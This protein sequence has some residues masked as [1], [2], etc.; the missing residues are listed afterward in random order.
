MY[1]LTTRE[2]QGRYPGVSPADTGWLTLRYRQVYSQI[3]KPAGLVVPLIFTELGVDGLV[4]ERP[5][6]PDARGWKDFQNFWAENGYGLWGPGA[7]IEQLAWY[8]E[9]M[10]QD[11]YVVGGCIYAM[12]ASAGWE[13]YDILGPAGAVLEQYLSV[14][15]PA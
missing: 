2:N 7:Y 8:D 5:G 1:Y 11:D 10:R 14:H 6:P 13:S 4:T 9:A 3:L 15:S 12:A